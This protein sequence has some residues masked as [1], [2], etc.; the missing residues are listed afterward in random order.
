MRVG[1]KARMMVYLWARLTVVSLEYWKVGL[2]AQA[3]VE[4]RAARSVDLRAVLMAIQ[5][6][7]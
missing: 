6:A 4:L 5:S 1:R 2:M 3:W 7:D